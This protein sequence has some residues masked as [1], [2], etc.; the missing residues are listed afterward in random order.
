MQWR[1]EPDESSSES[2]SHPPTNHFLIIE[3]AFF[4]A[5]QIQICKD[6]KYLIISDLRHGNCGTLS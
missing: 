1:L 4:F 5:F 3:Y 6:L 2:L